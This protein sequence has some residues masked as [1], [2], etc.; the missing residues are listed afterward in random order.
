MA[1]V[2][3]TSS[4]SVDM[5]L[6]VHVSQIPDLL[7]GEALEAAAPCY[8]HS[9]GKVYM[10]NGT[11]ADAEARCAGFTA[12]PVASGEPVTLLG[13]GTRFG[14]ADATMTP[15]A[16]LYLGT[17]NGRLDTATTT[18]DAVGVAIAVTA[19]DIL[20]TAYK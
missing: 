2:V 19:S 10:S 8:I 20:V 15:G 1:L 17:T 14:Y 4:P 7:A 16:K 9:D 6:A 11:A 12:R 13:P 5:S 18:G 3:K